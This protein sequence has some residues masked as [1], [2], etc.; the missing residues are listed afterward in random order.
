MAKCPRCGS[1]HEKLKFAPL[2]AAGTK[3]EEFESIA[4]YGRCPETRQPVLVDVEK[5]TFKLI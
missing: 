1:S 4:M 3:A 2:V 5:Q